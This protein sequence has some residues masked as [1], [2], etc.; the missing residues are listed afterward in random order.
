MKKIICVV[1]LSA[2]AAATWFGLDFMQRQHAK[3]ITHG[4]LLTDKMID[5][6]NVSAK[7]MVA[8]IRSEMTQMVLYER[9]GSIKRTLFFIWLTGILIVWNWDI[10]RRDK[11]IKGEPIVGAGGQ[12]APHR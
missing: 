11:E 2:I 9:Y 12:P 5:S 8:A 1:I 7:E 4:M 3:I 10:G 6:N